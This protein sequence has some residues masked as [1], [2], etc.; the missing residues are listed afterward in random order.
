[1]K[2][3]QAELARILIVD[4]EDH[5]L[6]TYRKSLEP[7]LAQGGNFSELRD[8]HKS[9]FGSN[10]EVREE[11]VYEL[12]FARQ[13]NEAVREVLASREEGRPFSVVFLDMRMPPGQGGFLTAKQIRAV[14]QRC[15]IVVV[16]AYSDV[17]VTEMA[18]AILPPDKFFYLRKPFYPQEIQ[19]F[20]AGLTAKWKA[21]T[22]LEAMVEERTKRLVQTNIALH[23]EMDSREK[24]EK[25]LSAS[26]KKICR[27]EEELMGVTNA[28][29][30]LF[31]KK[32]N[33][34]QEFE[35]NML[36]NVHQHI[37][38]YLQKLKRC[39]N[40]EKRGRYFNIIENNL[41]NMVSPFMHNLSLAHINLSPE[42]LNIAH[43]I[44]QG[45]KSAEIGEL[46]GLN[47]RT[48]DYYRDRLREKLG[49]KLSKKSLKE[50]LDE[51]KL[52]KKSQ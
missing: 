38:P 44:S 17:E 45:I 36:Y 7:Q 16:T 41:E 35:N 10:M 18:T 2:K 37:M 30:I 31:R 49:L 1:M 24:M 42:E 33:A 51:F 14:D 20:A 3:A 40:E 39:D 15:N 23:Q 5:I 9:I 29:E 12:V 32:F 48:I 43:L 6:E 8:M 25:E 21:E 19:Q 4:D 34:Q 27:Q 50:A 26:S 22:I 46:L 28:I 11:A 13:G 52:R 47:K